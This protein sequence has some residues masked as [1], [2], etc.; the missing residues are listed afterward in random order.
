M[1]DGCYVLSG[2][3]VRGRWSGSRGSNWSNLLYKCCRPNALWMFVDFA[4]SASSGCCIKMLT[5]LWYLDKTRR[6][7]ILDPLPTN[8]PSV[9]R[10]IP[11]SSPDALPIHVALLSFCLA[12]LWS[13]TQPMATLHALQKFLGCTCGQSSWSQTPSGADLKKPLLSTL[14]LCTSLY[15][16]KV[17]L[18]TP[19]SASLIGSSD[20]PF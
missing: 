11:C 12:L 20:I 1:V 10:Y 8:M 18:H 9:E 3:N 14:W 6:M 15:C 13:W 17:F 16:Y 7:G 2:W 5:L 19:C 4:S